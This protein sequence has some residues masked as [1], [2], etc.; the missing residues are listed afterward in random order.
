MLWEDKVENWRN[1]EVTKAFLNE[2]RCDLEELNAKLINASDPTEIWR[3]Q[4]MC[5]AY[6]AVLDIPEKDGIEN[7][8]DAKE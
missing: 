3:L 7:P 2:L 8:E 1:D 6:Q 5:R 4:G